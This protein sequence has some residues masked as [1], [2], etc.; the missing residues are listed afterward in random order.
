MLLK[1]G[2]EFDVS[3]EDG[4]VGSD[5]AGKA[6]SEVTFSRTARPGRIQPSSSSKFFFFW[7]QIVDDPLPTGVPQQ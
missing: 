7:G 1:E 4:D 2:E 5:S 3:L 6:S